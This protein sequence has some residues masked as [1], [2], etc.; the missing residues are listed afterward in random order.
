MKLAE[1]QAIAERV[2]AELAPFCVRCEI[3]GSIRRKRP[4]P[5]DLEIVCVPKTIPG[6]LF[7]NMAIRDPGFV[8]VMKY[9]S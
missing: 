5:R 2:R 7:K 8:Q 6:G 4:E 1:A 9:F 3:A